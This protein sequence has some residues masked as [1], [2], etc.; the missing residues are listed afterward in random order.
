MIAITVLPWTWQRPRCG[1]RTRMSRSSNGLTLSLP[2]Q[3]SS[4]ATPAC[5]RK[6]MEALAT[7]SLF[8]LLPAL[9]P[10]CYTVAFIWVRTVLLIR[11]RFRPVVF[12]FAPSL[13]SAPPLPRPLL[14]PPSDLHVVLGSGPFS[15]HPQFSGDLSFSF[16]WM[17]YDPFSIHFIAFHS[18]EGCCVFHQKR[19]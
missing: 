7:P 13:P 11:R 15:R 6:L 4:P 19:A 14:P 10:L 16:S 17:K 8:L 3:R 12:A 1:R 18:Q 2:A 9:P 5:A